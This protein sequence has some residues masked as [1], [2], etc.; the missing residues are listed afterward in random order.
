M[1]YNCPTDTQGNGRMELRQLRYFLALAEHRNFS[2]AA[3]ALGITQQALSYSTTQLERKLQAKL[4][5]RTQNH[6]EITEVGRALQKRARLI[7]G[8]ADLA[9]RE[10]CA[11]STGSSGAVAFGVSAEIAARFLPEIVERFT[12]SRPKVTLTIEVE[13]SSRLYD[14]LASGEL[15]FVVAT[16]AFDPVV[17]ATLSHERF[18]GGYVLDSNFLL[19]RTGHPLLSLREPSIKDAAKFPWLMPATLPKFTQQLFEMF[20]RAGAGPPPRIVRTD[21]FWCACSI[22]RRTDFVA[23]AGREPAAAEIDAKTI[24]GFPVPMIEALRST[25]MSTRLHSP[26]QSATESLMGLFRS[27]LAAPME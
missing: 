4:F 19:M 1:G 16:P 20:E 2:R 26:I 11:L 23:L 3:A 5:E 18:S 13:M 7:C 15:E 24:S 9:E 27:L 6:T 14:R 25:I 22:I 17:Y 10:V 8:E 12:R 21:S